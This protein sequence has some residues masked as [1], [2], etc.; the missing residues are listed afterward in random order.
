MN[1]LYAIRSFG[2]RVW[3][4]SLTRSLLTSGRLSALIETEGI[5][6]VT[7]NPT[8]FYNAIREDAC[9]QEQLA[10]VKQQSG[11]GEQ[12]Y[13]ALIIP[14]ICAACDVMLP[15]YQASQQ[16]DGYVS[17]EVSPFIAQ[18][19]QQ[20]IHEALRLWQKVDRP[21]L[22]IKIP[23]NQEGIEAF[24]VL[25]TE[26]LNVNITLLFSLPQVNRVWDAYIAG[27]EQRLKNKQAI[28]HVKAVASFFLSRIDHAVDPLVPEKFKGKVAIALAKAAYYEY[29]QRFHG[30]GF[31]KLKQAGARPNYLLWAST[32]TKDPAYSDVLYVEQLIGPETITTLP[33]ITLNKF[34]E[35]GTASASL[36]KASNASREALDALTRD[37]VD[38][39]ALG[40]QLQKEGLVSFERSFTALL[41]LIKP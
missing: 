39:A 18:D 40:E 9:Y 32:A 2:Q 11:D 3:L 29:F 20:T 10:A 4:D 36:E 31:A 8:I 1:R 7:S 22:M 25:I 38:L 28:G 33:E 24:R 16:E 6:G 14:D 23:G 34:R 13:E 37:G 35:H 19:T 5:A 15:V 17:L 30:D 21:N 26:G 12:A 41:A 27:L